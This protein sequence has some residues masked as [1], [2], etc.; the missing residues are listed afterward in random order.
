MTI[1]HPWLSSAVWDSS[2]GLAGASVL[3]L[4]LAA[5]LLSHAWRNAPAI[6]HTVLLSG[7]TG[8]LAVPIVALAVAVTGTPLLSFPRTAPFRPPASGNRA[9]AR[10]RRRW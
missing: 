5:V 7:L 10:G 8:C 2:A 1:T 9:R 6:R 4:S 3:L